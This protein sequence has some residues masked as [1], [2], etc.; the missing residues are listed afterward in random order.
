M[1]D[2]H[3]R[4]PGEGRGREVL[5]PAVGVGPGQVVAV[6]EAGQV[7]ADR[8]VPGRAHRQGDPE[9]QP[10]VVLA[11]QLAQPHR[12]VDVGGG[13]HTGGVE[14]PQQAAEAGDQASV[15]GVGGLEALDHRA[16]PVTVGT[17]ASSRSDSAVT[18]AAG[19]RQENTPAG[20]PSV[21][22]VCGPHMPRR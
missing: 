20:T 22:G 13:Q 5:G 19:G 9:S 12:R 18:N 15:V 16:S 1:L 14:G 4:G 11:D 2:P 3:H 10:L 7:D 6:G 8:A 17:G 21:V